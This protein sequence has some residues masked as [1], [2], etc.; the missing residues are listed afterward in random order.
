MLENTQCLICGENATVC[1]QSCDI[2]ECSKCGRYQINTFDDEP[3]FTEEQKLI[4]RHYLSSLSYNDPR[5][6][7]IIGESN[8]SEIIAGIDYPKD[9]L[10]KIDYVL[11]YFYDKTNYVNEIITIDQQSDSLLRHLFCYNAQE[12]ISILKYLKDEELI[13]CL[14]TAENGYDYIL[15]MKGMKYYKD[16][17]IPKN[18]SQQCFVAM[19]FNPIDDIGNYRFNMQRVYNDAIRPAI[20]NEQRESQIKALKIDC[21]EHCN[22]INDEMIAQIRQSRCM[23]VDL[24]GYRGGVYWEAGFGEGLGLPVI[25]TCNKIWKDGDSEKNI[26]HVHFDLEHR[27]MI[28]WEYDKLEEFKEKLTNRINAIIV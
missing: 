2:F 21:V 7:T 6:L 3:E 5:R 14:G 26:E 16:K 23:V 20:E 11:R 1:H 25:Y 19:W 8:F 24:T 4:L 13:K 15:T 9:L 18:K 27:N 28:L 17:I 12:F 22:D 10:E